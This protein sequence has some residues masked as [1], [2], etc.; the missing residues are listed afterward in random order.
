MVNPTQLANCL[1]TGAYEAKQQYVPAGKVSVTGAKATGVQKVDS[2][3]NKPVDDAEKA[4]L[5]VKKG[6]ALVVVT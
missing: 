2:F 3:F 1:L 4:V 5:E 6:T